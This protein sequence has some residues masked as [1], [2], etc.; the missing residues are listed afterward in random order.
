M[1]FAWNIV[2]AQQSAGCCLS[3]VVGVLDLSKL[4]RHDTKNQILNLFKM[5]CSVMETRQRF[6]QAVGK[7][8]LLGCVETA[9]DYEPVMD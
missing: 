1:F 5:L 7:L 3:C 2:H 9:I 6:E 8:L 4:K